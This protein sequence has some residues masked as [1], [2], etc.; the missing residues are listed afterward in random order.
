MHEEKRS[1]RDGQGVKGNDQ[2]C[3]AGGDV[4]Q[5]GKKADVVTEHAGESQ[6]KER[7]PFL[8]G[9][10][11]YPSLMDDGEAEQ[12]QGGDGEANER[13]TCWRHC[14]GQC[15]TGDE[16]SAPEQRGQHQAGIGYEL[17]LLSSRVYESHLSE[18]YTAGSKRCQ[19]QNTTEELLSG[20]PISCLGRENVEDLGHFWYREAI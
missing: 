13:R 1:Q 17:H 6:Q 20:W 4:L 14:S 11:G 18:A 10:P 8:P 2:C 9:R 16:G 19:Q 3:P 15:P 7:Q 12:C 5:T